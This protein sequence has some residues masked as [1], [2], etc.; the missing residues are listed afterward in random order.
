VQEPL[1]VLGG[2]YQ[3]GASLGSGGFGEVFSGIDLRT[4]E[5]VALK[6]LVRLEPYALVLFK[7]EF[8][9][10]SDCVHPNLVKYH[11][12]ITHGEQWWL[13]MEY[14]DGV[15]L[16]SFVRDESFSGESGSTR[17]VLA[18]L[19]DTSIAT[20]TV[21]N[22]LT[23][24]QAVSTPIA[25]TPS[26]V[27]KL[28]KTLPQ[29]QEGMAYLHARGLIHRDL[30]PANIMVDRTGRVVV[31][32]FG[33]AGRSDQPNATTEI[34]G[35]LR[36]MS[37]E[38]AQ[39]QQATAASDW[40]SLGVILYMLLTG[41]PPYVGSATE[42]IKAKSQRLPPDPR[43]AGPALPA[44]LCERC[45]ALLQPDPAHRPRFLVGAPTSPKSANS[46]SSA[47]LPFVGRLQEIGALREHAARISSSTQGCLVL[48]H[49]ASGIGKSALIQEYLAAFRCQPGAVALEG[50]CYE[51]EAV[52]FKA[53]DGVVDALA[54]HLAA[55]P[56][57]VIARLLP[58]YAPQLAHL[59][60]V[61]TSIPGIQAA[62]AQ[63]TTLEPSE[64]R[65]RGLLALRELLVRLGE[66][67]PLVVVIDDLQWS[68]DD[69]LTAMGAVFGVPDPP[70]LMVIGSC[71][72]DHAAGGLEHIKASLG[73]A[74]VPLIELAVGPLSEDS[75][76]Q[77]ARAALAEGGLDGP[78]PVL[79]G[80]RNA[81]HGHPLLLLELSRTGLSE[82]SQPPTVSGLLAGRLKKLP[83]AALGLLG[84]LAVAGRPRPLL[85]L[86]RTVR[87]EQGTFDAMALLRSE[88]LVRTRAMADDEEVSLFHDQVAD[89]VLNALSPDT[90][91]DW[92][93]RLLIELKAAKEPE[94]EAEALHRHAFAS[95]DM[96]TAGHWALVAAGR[97]TASLAFERAVELYRIAFTIADRGSEVR[98]RLADV[99]AA[100]GRGPEAAHEY[101]RAG[102]AM[103]GAAARHALCRAAGQYLRSGQMREGLETAH[104]A[105]AVVGERM[106]STPRAM[107]TITVGRWM[108]PPW[109]EPLNPSPAEVEPALLER[110]D[111]LWEIAHGLGGI[112]TIRAAAMHARHLQLALRSGD[113]T[114]SSKGLAWEAI[115]TFALGGR[116]QLANGWQL[117]ERSAG[118]ALRCNQEHLRAWSQAAAGYGHWCEGRFGE[119]I[120][121]SIAA[122]ASYREEGHDVAWE[123]GS[124]MAWCLAPAL[125]AQ[126]SLTA[127]KSL[128]EEVELEFE[129]LGDR[130]TLT[131]MR[132]V[133]KPLL[134]FAAGKPELARAETSA[135]IDAWSREHWHL[136][137]LFAAFAHC[138]ADL[139][140][141]DCQT[142]LSALAV[143]RK[144][145]A[146]SFQNKL[147]IKRVFEIHLQTCALAMAAHQPGGARK[148]IARLRGEGR[149]LAA[150]GLSWATAH[151]QA[152]EAAALSAEGRAAE[153]VA[154]YVRAADAYQSLGMQLHH[155]AARRRAAEV[156][157]LREPSP[158]R[159]AALTAAEGQLLA[160]GVVEPA[161]LVAMLV[162]GAAP[163][164]IA[165]AAP[166]T[167][168]AAGA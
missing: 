78:E 27:Q 116:K 121:A 63:A 138:R 161:R 81:A 144:R 64:A 105:L 103:Q 150:E 34:V 133:A 112:D 59:F 39:G 152:A 86:R 108:H 5:R 130:Y 94:L 128:C 1:T 167:L 99:L 71:R 20:A 114:R 47:T 28:R 98:M 31:L 120:D 125:A 91:R 80:I 83:D 10:L 44:D 132:T 92:H 111:A 110:M 137:H 126:G 143:I 55:Q 73:H 9:L 60:P 52:P 129:R 46:V 19:P 36:Y 77:L 22:F 54:E 13:V 155:L 154:C 153:A 66:S 33:L 95:G 17:T 42:M 16:Q 49:G 84:C 141:G 134:H 104:A 165:A 119:A 148:H 35:T 8:R 100:A 82:G 163:V 58:R 21:Q 30:K 109:K 4:R 53:L 113:I 40:Y 62:K 139:Y 162:P 25:L 107:W 43:L 146:S 136:Q 135:A 74:G 87:I 127:L 50:R 115:L 142:A 56:P 38:H 140:G 51:R 75:C 145:M 149:R 166:A 23:S 158:E 93:S 160:F 45:L 61:L 97:A 106:G 24:R 70:P 164:L 122:A 65:R 124:V 7:R 11:E 3:V 147:Q 79:T 156:G 15:D 29:L 72:T 117:V 12:L 151:A 2:R 37:P 157:Y 101:R 89:A 57:L 168:A 76:D 68:D 18:Q 32:D 14:V 90:T 69:S 6:H 88:R 159:V 26:Q 118:L 123:L 96:A 102:D 48:V 41:V 131:T 85:M 67:R